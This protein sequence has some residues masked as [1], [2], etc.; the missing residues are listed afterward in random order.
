MMHRQTGDARYADRAIA[1]QSATDA[2]FLIT[3][4]RAS[5]PDLAGGV[6]R[7]TLTPPTLDDAMLVASRAAALAT[8]VRDR[9]ERTQLRRHLEQGLR[10]LPQ[11]QIAD[12]STSAYHLRRPWMVEGGFRSSTVDPLMRVEHTAAALLAL[13]AALVSLALADASTEEP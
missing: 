3:R 8:A 13:D 2:R 4:G 5:R 11:E 7:T 12:R 10:F 1:M 9:R 6:H